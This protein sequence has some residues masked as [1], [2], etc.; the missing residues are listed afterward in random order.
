M[1]VKIAE[2]FMNQDSNWEQFLTE[3]PLAQFIFSSGIIVG[4][5][6][7]ADT[8]LRITNELWTAAVWDTEQIELLYGWYKSIPAESRAGAITSLTQLKGVLTARHSNIKK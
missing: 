7:N 2:R 8:A 6:F 1:F 3:G 4:F 5:E